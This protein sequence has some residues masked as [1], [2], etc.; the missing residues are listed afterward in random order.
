MLTPT[1]QSDFLNEEDDELSSSSSSSSL[2]LDA[3]QYKYFIYTFP[4]HFFSFGFSLTFSLAAG[5]SFTT[6]FFSSGSFFCF[7]T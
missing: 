7:F 5:F 2:F 4:I 3:K 1:K 6:F